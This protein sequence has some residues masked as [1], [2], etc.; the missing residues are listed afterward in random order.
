MSSVVFRA[1]PQPAEVINRQR[2]LVFSFNGRQVAALA[3]DT[4]VAALM[5]NGVRAY[6]QGRRL[7]RRRGVLSADRFD[8]SCLLQVDDEPNVPAAHRLVVNRHQVRSQHVWPSLRFDLKSLN[9]RIGRLLQSEAALR[10]TTGTGF[11]RPAYRWLA[12][13]G[14]VGGRL[15]GAGA[16][17]L[18]AGYEH[19]DVLVVGA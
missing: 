1:G 13:H 16:G 15:V 4:I 8:P 14:D 9:Q 19:P 6:A 2:L 7:Q 12:A 18:R 11:L 5:A 3:G 17:E 10:P